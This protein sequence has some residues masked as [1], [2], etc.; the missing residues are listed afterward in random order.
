MADNRQ[1]SHKTWERIDAILWKIMHRAEAARDH[2]TVRDADAA[3]A[4]L[5]NLSMERHMED[6]KFLEVARSSS[7]ATSWGASSLAN[8]TG[9]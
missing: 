3:I 1:M 7:W 6:E 4:L 2:E 5:R 9:E 8:D